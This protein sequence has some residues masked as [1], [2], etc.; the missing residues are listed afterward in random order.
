MTC[1]HVVAE[2][3]GKRLELEQQE[4]APVELSVTFD[5]VFDQKEHGGQLYTASPVRERWRP[6]K[7]TLYPRDV[8][9][10]RLYPDT[11]LPKDAMPVVACDKIGWGDGF[12][13]YGIKEGVPDGTYI[14]GIFVGDIPPDRV[15]VISERLDQAIRPG[16][17]GAGVWNT[18]RLGLAGMIVEMLSDTQGRVIPIEQLEKVWQF[19]HHSLDLPVSTSDALGGGRN[20]RIGNRLSSLLHTFDRE[21]QE[22]DFDHAI[23]TLWT[24]Q[25]RPIVC[26]ISGLADDRPLLCRDRC[27]RLPLGDLLD[28]MKLNGRPP[29]IRHIR[30]PGTNVPNSLLRLKQQVKWVLRAQDVTPQMVRK[31]YNDGVTPF[32]F[33]TQIGHSEFDQIDREI[34]LAWLD[35][36]REIG[37]E[38]LNK[39]LAVFILFELEQIP[40]SSFS[41]THYFDEQFIARCP[42]STVTLTRLNS[43]ARDAVVDWLVQTA[44]QLTLAED[45]LSLHVLPNAK[46]CLAETDLRLALLESWIDNLRI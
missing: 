43:F 12:Q 7:G 45:D 39:P 17:S 44:E 4:A 33:F 21:L 1:A 24:G 14:Q 38:P 8:A 46:S 22:A 2:A 13:A 9:V 11:T 30:W 19:V 25:Q 16:C 23:D 28:R 42:P 10:L 18:N 32:V 36:W 40:G 41:L 35:F 26:A 3:T 15:E 34:P 37:S 27:V 20:L 29:T 31:A 6:E 5:F